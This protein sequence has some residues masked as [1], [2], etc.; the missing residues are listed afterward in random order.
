M[1]EWRLTW[2]SGPERH[3]VTAE[4]PRA[5]RLRDYVPKGFLSK[6]RALSTKGSLTGKRIEG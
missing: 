3:T 6:G 1:E 2:R 4:P 5:V